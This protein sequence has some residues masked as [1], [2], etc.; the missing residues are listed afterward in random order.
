MFPVNTMESTGQSRTWQ[1]PAED[2]GWLVDPCPGRAGQLASANREHLEHW[3]FDFGET[4]F[5][6][7]RASARESLMQAARDYT[8]AYQPGRSMPAVAPIFMTGHQPD[9]FHPGVWAKNFLLSHIADRQGGVAVN[10][11]VDADLHKSPSIRVPTGSK[12][13]PSAE[14][15]AYDHRSISLPYEEGVVH[16]PE[17]FRGFA[18][19]A[20]NKMET[21]LPDSILP[22]FWDSVLQ[23]WEQEPNVGQCF[24]RARH[25]LEATW[26]LQA[27]E[28]PL[29]S[30]C[31]TPAFLTFAHFLLGNAAKFWEAY[32]TCLDAYRTQHRIRSRTHPVPALAREGDSFELPLWT[33]TT[34][35]PRRRPVFARRGGQS[36]VLSDQQG[37]G[38]AIPETGQDGLKALQANF[39]ETADGRKLRPRA[40]ITTMFARLFLCDLF[41][42]G[43]GG[44][45]YD[46]LNDMIMERFWG[47]R[48]PRYMVASATQRLP[49]RRPAVTSADLGRLHS[50][51]RELV[52]HPEDHL[53]NNLK[54]EEVAKT[55]RWIQAKKQWVQTP[56]T[57]DNAR[58]RH[59]AITQA[60][61]SLQAWL[62]GRL[63]QLHVEQQRLEKLLRNEGVL[64]SRDYAF[65]LY[66]SQTLREMFQG[67][68]HRS[69]GT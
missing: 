56:K 20:R 69:C 44:G 6:E 66:P 41:V 9:L 39:L 46:R 21:L 13:H 4:S 27:W 61:E 62:E 16:D 36:I 58:T 35:S 57:V 40:L 1:A 22:E 32:N 51:Q 29:S 42:H 3:D 15:L 65:C 28:V 17:C 53:P 30:I 63:K 24:A 12:D 19:R 5:A 25:D 7:I 11:Q 50:L 68:E 8:L 14:W 47:I 31:R 64:G 38:T 23:H 45:I 54:P 26:G 33:W 2:G 49:I 37:W 67:L 18:D 52:Y 10:F 48:P 55:Q 43:I 34:D 60:N 59:I